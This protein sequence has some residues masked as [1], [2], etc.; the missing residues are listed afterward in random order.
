MAKAKKITKSELESVQSAVNG[1]NGFYMNIGRTLVTAL[2]SMD[3]L[4]SLEEVLDTEQK[5]LEEKYG[6]VTINLSN[7]EY[8]EVIEEAE[9]VAE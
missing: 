3:E 2:K 4:A 6:S 1:I 9:E 7:G 5:A 8:K